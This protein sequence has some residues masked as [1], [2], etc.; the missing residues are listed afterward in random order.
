MLRC[1]NLSILRIDPSSW[2]D[3]VIDTLTFVKYICVLKGMNSQVYTYIFIVSWKE[4]LNLVYVTLQIFAMMFLQN[5]RW[6]FWNSA[7]AQQL[8]ITINNDKS[9]REIIYPA[10]YK[11]NVTYS[12]EWT[13]FQE[14]A[15]KFLILRV[16][17]YI[18]FKC[19]HTSCHFIENNS[20]HEEN[21][22]S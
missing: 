17:S 3:S 14:N 1:N 21:N 16:T 13:P 8:C 4:D 11:T 9:H 20:R 10:F 5:V 19:M 6:K 18:S 2:I 15:I 12:R 7:D 22:Y